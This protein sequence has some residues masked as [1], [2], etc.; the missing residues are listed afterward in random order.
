MNKFDTIS[1]IWNYFQVCTNSVGKDFCVHIK[2][3]MLVEGQPRRSNSCDERRL[4][5]QKAPAATS[6]RPS[7]TQ[8]SIL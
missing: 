2:A 6:S 7:Q 1:K 4:Q 5:Q 3:N 8:F